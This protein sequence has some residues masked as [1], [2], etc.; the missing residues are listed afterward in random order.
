[1]APSAAGLNPHGLSLVEV[2]HRVHGAEGGQAV[3]GQALTHGHHHI[4]PSWVLSQHVVVHGS[5]ISG[6]CSMEAK[7]RQK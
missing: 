1:M 4:G 2:H 7:R 6:S 5:A 3:L